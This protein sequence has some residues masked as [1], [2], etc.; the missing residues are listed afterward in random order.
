[1]PPISC[2]SLVRHHHH[3]YEV[4]GKEGLIGHQGMDFHGALSTVVTHAKEFTDEEEKE[5][6]QK[7]RTN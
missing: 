1:M 6:K 3:N 2:H 5:K 4:L 7:S